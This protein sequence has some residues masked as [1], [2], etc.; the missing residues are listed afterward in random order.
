MTSMPA[1]RKHKYTARSADRHVLYQQ[2]VQTPR[3]DAGYIARLFR[4]F[5]GRPAELLRE[6]FCGTAALS[7]AWV[8]L[9]RSHHALG[10][11]RNAR[12]LSWAK[13]H[14]LGVL[15]AEQ[16]ERITLLRANVLDVTRPRA[17]VVA[18][19]NFSYFAFKTRDL[20]RRYFRVVR[21][22]LA[23]DGLLLLDAFGGS[24]GQELLIERRRCKGFTYLWEHAAFDPITNGIRCHIHFQFPDGGRMDKAF[25]YNWRLWSLIEIQEV[26]RESGFA[27][28]EVHWEATNHRTGEGNGK[29]RRTTRGQAIPSWVAHIIALR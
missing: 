2:A 26:L 20:L 13:R 21:G 5:R 11:D 27:R 29:F 7:C 14:N 12:T 22:S 16:R 8:R 9:R 6:D 1:D 28:V 17:D 10:V 4:R 18:A 24:E 3:E 19:L 15:D 25:T 23:A